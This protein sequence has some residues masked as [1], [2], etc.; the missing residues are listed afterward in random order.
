LARFRLYRSGRKSSPGLAEF[1][2][3]G[4]LEG[5]RNTVGTD[6]YI[7][8]VE[9]INILL[10][11]ALNYPYQ[12]IARDNGGIRARLTSAMVVANI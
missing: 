4:S 2:E 11:T 3:T 6:G 7:V 1:V 5:L 8:E 9:K 10:K 12:S